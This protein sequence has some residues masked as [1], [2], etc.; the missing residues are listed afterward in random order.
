[1]TETIDAVSAPELPKKLPLLAVR[2]VVFFPH[3]LLPLS[4]GRIRSIR[5]LEAAI[6]DG[7]KL[8]AVVAQKDMRI[9]EPQISDVYTTGVLASVEQFLRMPD[10]T[11]KVFF[12]GNFSYFR[13]FCP[14][15][16]GWLLG[17]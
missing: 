1:M 12:A 9:E 14:R 10:G 16:C 15:S 13:S 4:V 11:L 8:L 5:A 17:S 7:K 2:D 3:T 6:K